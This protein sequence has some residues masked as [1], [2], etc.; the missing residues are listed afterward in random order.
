MFQP[1]RRNSARLVEIVP[2]VIPMCALLVCELLRWAARRPGQALARAMWWRLMQ[3]R[4][5][6]GRVMQG[7]SG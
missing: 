7:W 6:A 1:D 2:V 5:G 4:H 3:T